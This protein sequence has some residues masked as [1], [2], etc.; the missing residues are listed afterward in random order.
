MRTKITLILAVVVVPLP[1]IAMVQ[2]ASALKQ[3]KSD[4]IR[5]QNNQEILCDSLD[6]Y[7]ALDGV[8]CYQIRRL[9]MSK[10]EFERTNLSLKNELNNMRIKIKNLQSATRT[11]TKTEYV[12]IPDTIYVDAQPIYTYNDAWLSF[13]MDSAIHITSHDT[14]YVVR[15]QKVKKFLWWTRRKDSYIS[16]ENRNPHTTITSIQTIDID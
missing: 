4:I 10:R 13:R 14:I 6:S 5:L 11:E 1:L 12:F 8:N 3:A 15:H 9:E 2:L 16:V 7:K